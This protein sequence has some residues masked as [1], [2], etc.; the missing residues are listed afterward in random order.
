MKKGLLICLTIAGLGLV[1]CKKCQTCT[2]TTFQEVSGITTQTAEVAEDYCGDAYNDAPAEGTVV[3][4]LGTITQSVTISCS[5][6]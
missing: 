5:D 3:Q 2:T 1:S 6:K 4:D